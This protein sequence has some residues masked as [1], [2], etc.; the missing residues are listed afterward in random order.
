M[1]VWQLYW[2]AGDLLPSLSW[3]AGKDGPTIIQSELTVEENIILDAT[4][5]LFITEFILYYY[6]SHNYILLY[7]QGAVFE[8]STNF[9]LI[10]WQEQP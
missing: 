4:K 1:G 6:I 10:L 7:V 5:G 9:Y 8:L 3:H 2:T